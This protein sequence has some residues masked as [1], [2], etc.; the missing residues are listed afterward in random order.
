VKPGDPE[1]I[2]KIVEAIQRY[3][4]DL[5]EAPPLVVGAKNHGT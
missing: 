4:I 1:Q 5:N 2:G 3:W